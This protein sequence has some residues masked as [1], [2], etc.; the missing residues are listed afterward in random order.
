MIGKADKIKAGKGMKG[1][2]VGEW[3]RIEG[4][5]GRDGRRAE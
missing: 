4:T 1:E 5:S 2:E 3:K